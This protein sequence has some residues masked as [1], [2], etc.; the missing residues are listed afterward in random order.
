[1][2][3]KV[4]RFRPISDEKINLFRELLGA[5]N[6]EPI[7]SQ[8]N[9]DTAWLTFINRVF[10]LYDRV[11]PIKTKTFSPKS[12]TKPWINRDIVAKIKKRN[13]LYVQH[14]QGKVPKTELNSLRNQITSDI[15]RSKNNFY[16]NE[17]LKFRSDMLKTWS[18]IN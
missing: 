7:I 1:M 17:F 10:E 3:A 6:F 14:L 11:F 12:E 2:K 9:I 13:L 8:T 15:K 4:I 18:T 16:K 5:E